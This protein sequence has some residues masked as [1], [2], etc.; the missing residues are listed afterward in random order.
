MSTSGGRTNSGTNPL[1]VI[2]GPNLTQTAASAN[3]AAAANVAATV[4]LPAIAGNFLYLSMLLLSVGFAAAAVTLACTV[5]GL[6]GGTWT[7]DLTGGTASGMVIAVPLSVPVKS[8]AVNTA[9]VA[10]VPASGASGPAISVQAAG[11]Y[12][13]T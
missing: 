11:F 2:D 12:F 10:T 13:P 6:T 5:T 9:I 7:I 3:Q 4:T 8:S 1:T